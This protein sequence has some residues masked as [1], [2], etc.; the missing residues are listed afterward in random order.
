MTRLGEGIDFSQNLAASATQENEKLNSGN[1]F[2]LL[3]ISLGIA[4]RTSAFG[5]P[6]LGEGCGV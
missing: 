5:D 3:Q 4:P 6:A 1:A 2:C